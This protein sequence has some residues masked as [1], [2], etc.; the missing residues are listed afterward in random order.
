MES[1]EHIAVLVW[2]M[3]RLPALVLFSPDALCLR[4]P[5]ET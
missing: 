5:N 2:E 3:K 1:R 4:V